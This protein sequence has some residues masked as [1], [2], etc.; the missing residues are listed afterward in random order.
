MELMSILKNNQLFKGLSDKEVEHI[1]A[2]CEKKEYDGSSIIFKESEELGRALYKETLL[3]IKLIHA[4]L[5]R[6][7]Q[8][9]EDLNLPV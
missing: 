3:L 7:I 2:I 1:A 6:R 8:N 9:I 5:E 4:S